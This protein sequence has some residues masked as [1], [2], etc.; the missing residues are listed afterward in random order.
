MQRNDSHIAPHI[1]Q[2]ENTN[3]TLFSI[4]DIETL[5]LRGPIVMAN[6]QVNLSQDLT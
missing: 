4:A 3:L 1:I 6:F 5:F 2:K